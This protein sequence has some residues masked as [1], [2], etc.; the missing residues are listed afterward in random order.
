M[1][2]IGIRYLKKVKMSLINKSRVKKFA[3]DAANK[4]RQIKAERKPV[5]SSGRAWNM[6]RC[7]ALAEQKKFTQVSKDFLENV[8]ADLR[9]MI[10]KKVKSLPS[11]GKTI[12]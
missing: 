8:E 12:K 10:E 11:V 6:E 5:G 2:K 1:P 7:N 3:L 4:R 9:N